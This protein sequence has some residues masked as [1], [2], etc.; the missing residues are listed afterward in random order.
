M[1]QVVSTLW[2]WKDAKIKLKN[3]FLLMVSR[4]DD[5]EQIALLWAQS[6]SEKSNKFTY[7]ASMANLHSFVVNLQRRIDVTL[8]ATTTPLKSYWDGLWKLWL[9]SLINW[10]LIICIKWPPIFKSKSS[11]KLSFE[12]ILT[13]S[14]LSTATYQYPQPW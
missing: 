14:G 13:T 9:Q 4:K 12:I 6:Y 10:K 2:K 11:K 7:L 1:Y 5:D 3:F 8:V